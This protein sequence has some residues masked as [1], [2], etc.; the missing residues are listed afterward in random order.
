MRLGDDENT[1]TAFAD[2]ISGLTSR[3]ERAVADF[4]LAAGTRAAAM[5][6]QEV[7]AGAGTSDATVVRAAKSLGFASFR[8]LRR[9]LAVPAPPEVAL[10]DRLRATLAEASEPDDQLAA[11]IARQEAG[12]A[13]LGTR[14]G[15]VFGSAVS[16]LARASHVWWSGTGPSGWLAGYGAFLCRRLGTASGAL[17]HAGTD[18]ADELLQL[19]SGD[20]TVILAY[21]RLHPHARVTIE[22]ANA[23]GASVVLLT[24]DVP[25]PKGLDVGVTLAAGR[26]AAGRF[27]SHGATIVVIEA[28]VLGVAAAH[29]DRST[30]S[31]ETL[32]ELRHAIAGRRLD[33][34]PG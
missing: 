2:G 1:T 4:L 20:A 34:D 27:A 26:G 12:L 11:A 16:L 21:G 7:A 29:P 5:S 14:L 32:N 15:P 18:S 28:L 22:R 3:A 33:V 24:D 10:G 13:G 25:S 6:A 19:S 17:T 23:V 30:T 8:E 31:V 9:A